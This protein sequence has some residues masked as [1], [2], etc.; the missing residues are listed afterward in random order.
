MRCGM[1]VKLM[2]VDTLIVS[3]S[4]LKLVIT[5]TSIERSQNEYQTHRPHPTNVTNLRN[6]VKSG[7]STF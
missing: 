1:P 6:L 5:E 2:K 4:P 7:Q 3:D